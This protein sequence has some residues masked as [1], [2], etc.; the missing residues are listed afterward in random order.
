MREKFLGLNKQGLEW[1]LHLLKGDVM[2]SYHSENWEHFQ[3][4]THQYNMVRRAYNKQYETGELNNGTRTN[5][6]SN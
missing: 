5:K 1:L 6:K 4:F 3:T 2:D